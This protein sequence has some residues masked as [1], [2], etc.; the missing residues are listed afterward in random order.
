MIVLSAE[1][2]L[3]GKMKSVLMELGCKGDTVRIIC[4]CDSQED[5]NSKAEQLGLGS[6]WFVPECCEEARG[7]EGLNLLNVLKDNDMALCVDGKNFLAID[8]EVRDMLL[9]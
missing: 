4:K 3:E 5:A 9:R 7:N 1:R 2:A 6:R 8:S